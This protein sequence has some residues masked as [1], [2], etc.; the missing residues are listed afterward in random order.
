MADDPKVTAESSA[1]AKSPAEASTYEEIAAA[2]GD[3]DIEKPPVE[4]KPEPVKT[5]EGTPPPEV[6]ENHPTKL[7]RK[8]KDLS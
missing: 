2:F 7:G 1:D 5:D 6:D 8:V 3:E 4:T